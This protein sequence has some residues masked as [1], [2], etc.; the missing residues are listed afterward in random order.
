MHEKA[1]KADL[2]SFDKAFLF[3]TLFVVGGVIMM[4]ELLGTRILAPFFGTTIY[5][6]SSLI[7]VTL[8]ALAI[9]YFVG[10]KIADRKPDWKIIYLVIF[11]ACLWILLIPILRPTILIFGNS[12]PLL[13]GSLFSAFA[14][15]TLP[16]FL[17]GMV[18]PFAVKLETD[19]LG[20]LGATA[21]SLFA[22]STLGSLVGTVLTG[23]YLIPRFSVGVIMFLIALLLFGVVVIWSLGRRSWRS[24]LSFSMV[25]ILLALLSF[26]VPPLEAGSAVVVYKAESPYGQIKVVDKGNE[27]I[28]LID[29]TL[30]TTVRKDTGEHGSRYVRFMEISALLSPS[31][32]DALVIGL[33][34]GVFSKRLKEGYHLNVETVEVDPAVVEVAER[35]FDF[36]GEVYV[37]DGRYFLQKTEKK[38]DIIAIDAASPYN[39]PPHLVTLE[40]FKEVRQ[41]LRDE[42]VFVVNINV[43][44]G[45]M[46]SK[47][48][49]LTLGQVFPEVRAYHVNPEGLGNMVFFSMLEEM[50]FSDAWRQCVGMEC[51]VLENMLYREVKM[52]VD[53][54]RVLSDSYN[55]VEIWQRE[56][57]KVSRKTHLHYLGEEVM[58]S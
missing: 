12:F 5:T 52:D 2:N 36:E 27:R 18:T 57:D 23:F 45:S 22:V 15:F 19:K 28:L 31:A 25:F 56:A 9:G 21:G 39:V 24:L 32:R 20:T 1:L 16:L 42:G 6:W 40:M 53:A 29:N 11:L 43:L 58:L 10:G 55:P 51:M 41:H 54:A 7:T 8:F 17:L 50:D 35:Y 37:Q 14:L 44:P 49:Y 30:Q 38:Y 33:G 46:L 3:L 48:L 13:F 47:S 26:L 4:L 34:G